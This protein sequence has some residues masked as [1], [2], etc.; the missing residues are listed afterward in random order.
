MKTKRTQAMTLR[1]D[2]PINELLN[3]AAWQRKLSKAA[4]V[5]GAIRQRLGLDHQSAQKQEKFT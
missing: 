3:E 2:L 5:R 1:L 4:Y